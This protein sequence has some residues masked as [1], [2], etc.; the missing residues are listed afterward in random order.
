MTTEAFFFKIQ[1][2]NVEIVLALCVCFISVIFFKC[3]MKM[4]SVALQVRQHY[5]PYISWKPTPSPL[6]DS[7]IARLGVVEVSLTA[8]TGDEASLLRALFLHFKQVT[9]LYYVY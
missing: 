8:V 9:P 7:T 6:T 1:N 5:F 4:N 3:Y 2:I